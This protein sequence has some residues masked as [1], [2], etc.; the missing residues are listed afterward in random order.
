MYN[1]NSTLIFI[2]FY[3]YKIQTAQC[4]VVLCIRNY[5]PY[6]ARMESFTTWPS[7]S[8]Q[9]PENLS[10]AGFFYTGELL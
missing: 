5:W 9:K 3:S 7:A 10:V 1:Y 4:G 8:K 2:V 6:N